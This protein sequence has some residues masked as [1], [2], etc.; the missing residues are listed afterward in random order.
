MEHPS[1]ANGRPTSEESDRDCCPACGCGEMHI[2]SYAKKM[3]TI[4]AGV[5]GPDWVQ[6]GEAQCGHCG[7]VFGH[8]QLEPVKVPT[9]RHC[10][11][12]GAENFSVDHTWRR[13]KDGAIR[14]RRVCRQCGQD[15]YISSELPAD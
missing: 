4:L 14:R 1:S 15:G 13:N 5:P 8:G 11:A 6:Q 12:K 10:G 7:T 9:C 2:V 3:P